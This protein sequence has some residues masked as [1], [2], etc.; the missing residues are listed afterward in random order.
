MFRHGL[1]VHSGQTHHH[2]EQRR[3]GVNHWIQA[4]A[5]KGET[6]LASRCS[7]L[8]LHGKTDASLISLIHLSPY[9]PEL[10]VQIGKL[11]EICS[12]S[13]PAFITSC[14]A[15]VPF[16][17]EV[18]ITFVVWQLTWRSGK[19]V[20]RNTR[21]LHADHAADFVGS[22]HFRLLDELA[23]YGRRASGA[24]CQYQLAG[25]Q[26]CGIVD[27]GDPGP[28]E[29]NNGRFCARGT[30]TVLSAP[31]FRITVLVKVAVRSR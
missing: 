12:A 25:L 19:R 23:L 8:R 24:H 4:V 5:A 2:A 29:K 28:S 7:A 1:T 31:Q 17:F 9:S 27:G 3:G 14:R 6:V 30:S 18:N 26:Q 20:Q 21:H 15:G 22:G 16:Q 11:P 13:A 10:E